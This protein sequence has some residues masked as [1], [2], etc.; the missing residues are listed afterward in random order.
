MR[1]STKIAA[2]GWHRR[3]GGGGNSDLCPLGRGGSPIDVRRMSAEVDAPGLPSAGLRI[4]HPSDMHFTGSGQIE[5][6]KIE[7]TVSLVAGGDRPV[8]GDWRSDPR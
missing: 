3:N 7:R 1:S 6:W 8:A 5:R 4:L 2:A